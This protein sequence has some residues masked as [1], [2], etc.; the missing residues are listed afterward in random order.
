MKLDW[1]HEYWWSFVFCHVT[2]C[3][4]LPPRHEVRRAA[5]SDRHLFS[6]S[7]CKSSLAH[8]RIFTFTAFFHFRDQ[9]SV[10]SHIHFLL[11][12]ARIGRPDILSSVNKFA[13]AVA[14]WTQACD[15]RLARLISF[16]LITQVNSDNIVMMATRLSIVDWV[17][18]KTQ[19]LLA[20]LKTRNQLSERV[21][22][23]FGS[24]TFG[25]IS[26]MCKK[27]T[28]V[29]HIST[30]SEIISLDAGLRMDGLF[31]LDLWDTVIEVL[32]STNNTAR[33]GIPAQ[34]DL[35]GTGDHAIN[36]NKTKIPTEKR[37][38]EVWAIVKCGLR[39]YPPTHILLKARLSCTFFKTTKQSSKWLSKAEV[40]QW[41]T[42]PEP[43]ELHLIGCPTESTWKQR[44]KSKMLTPKI[45]SLTC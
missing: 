24:R 19:T 21:L 16:R 43:T 41:D 2:V 13:R 31:A 17:Y 29:S 27:Q 45:N 10:Q 3:G 28:S 40:Q 7:L 34:G 25:S 42:C 26:W 14:K 38:R 35:R 33:K 44:S 1:V 11:C 37:T 39:T 8:L 32:S 36:K 23:I 18:S 4:W 6:V 9:K 20:A 30:E 12:L 5:A 15:R 22:C